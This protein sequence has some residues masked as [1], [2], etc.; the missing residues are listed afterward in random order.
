[1]REKFD[2]Y[3]HKN[4]NT[5]TIF[6]NEQ[7]AALKSLR[8]NGKRQPL[9][10]DEIL[11]LINDSINLYF[12]YKDI[13]LTNSNIDNSLPKVYHEENNASHI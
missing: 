2:K 13:I 6:T 10:Y 12:T 1:M 8:I 7:Y 11:Y 9:T 5:V 4:G 3:L